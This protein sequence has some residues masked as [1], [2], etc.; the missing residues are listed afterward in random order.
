[1]I[2]PIAPRPV[3]VQLMAATHG[4]TTPQTTVACLLF[5]CKPKWVPTSTYKY[6]D[7]V[8]YHP[9]P[10]IFNKQKALPNEHAQTITVTLTGMRY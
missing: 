1:M 10:D 4:S 2:A 5:P 9:V 6:G 7:V 8:L 3:K